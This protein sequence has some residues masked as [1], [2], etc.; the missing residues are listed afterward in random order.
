MIEGVD[1]GTDVGRINSAVS[2]STGAVIRVVLAS[3]TGSSV[4]VERGVAV[5]NVPG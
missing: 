3:V 4:G 2:V 1:E 5:G